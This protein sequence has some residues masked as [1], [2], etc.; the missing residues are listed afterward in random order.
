MIAAKTRMNARIRFEGI[1]DTLRRQSIRRHEARD[2]HKSTANS[3]NNCAD[4]GK[5][6]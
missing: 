6:E 1:Y 3:R 4:S 5:P 2:I